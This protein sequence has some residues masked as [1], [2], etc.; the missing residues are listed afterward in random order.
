[1]GAPLSSLVVEVFF[2]TDLV[3]SSATPHPHILAWYR[4][5]DDILGVWN[6]LSSDLDALPRVLQSDEEICFQETCEWF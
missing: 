6:A 5:V 3:H 2:E 1:M 4:H